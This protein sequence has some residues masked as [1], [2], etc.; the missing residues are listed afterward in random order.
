MENES[1]SE[2]LSP[3]FLLE[4]GESQRKDSPP[5]LRKE[6]SEMKKDS[7]ESVPGV[8]SYQRKCTK[9]RSQTKRGSSKKELV[10][11]PKKVD[12]SPKDSKKK[13]RVLTN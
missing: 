11:T 12:A 6:S 2:F 8:R 1:Y 4:R 3:E 5:E 13:I 10:L 7:H 9:A